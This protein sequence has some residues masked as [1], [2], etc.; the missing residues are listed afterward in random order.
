MR[1]QLSGAKWSYYG[2]VR[3]LSIDG[4]S[5]IAG[6]AP[7]A[8]DLGVATVRLLLEDWCLDGLYAE[9][10]AASSASAEFRFVDRSDRCRRELRSL[11]RHAESRALARQDP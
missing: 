6:A 10:R 7:I 11:L 1:I 2:T 4:F 3:T 8:E 5:I 9:R